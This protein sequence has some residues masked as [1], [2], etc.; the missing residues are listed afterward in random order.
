MQSIISP[1]THTSKIKIISKICTKNLVN[2][3]LRIF[4]I[5]V[6]KSFISI[7]YVNVCECL[8]TGYIFFSPNSI[9]GDEDFYKSLEKIN[10]YYQDSKWEYDIAKNILG[11][12]NR[13]LE[14]GCGNGAFLNKIHFENDCIGLELNDNNTRDEPFSIINSTIEKYIKTDPLKFDWVVS[15]QLLEH[16]TDVKTYFDS[17][18]S[19]LQEKG[20]ILIAIPNNQSFFFKKRNTSNP[21][22]EYMQTLLLNSPPHHMGIW[23]KKSLEKLAILYDLK[24][25]QFISEPISGWR[26]EL[27]ISLLNEKLLFRILFKIIGRN[28]LYSLLSQ[29]YSPLR[30]GDT[31]IVIMKKNN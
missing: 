27:N 22:V 30:N 24:I 18:K 23:S 17:S 31:L 10:W 11:T 8:T 15:F 29:F 16:L 1:A 21:S 9:S 25:V 28:L 3:Y 7:D 13:I 4:N 26:R 20:K 14:V 6:S 2:D 5:D 19:V 12:D